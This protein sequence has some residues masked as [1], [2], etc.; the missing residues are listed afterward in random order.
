[1][2]TELPL[3]GADLRL[4]PG[5]LDR[6]AADALFERLLQAVPW[7][8]H[9]VRLFGRERA[10]PRLSCW[11]GDPGARY[12]YSGIERSP[13]EW[14]PELLPLRARLAAELGVDFN[15]VLANLYRSG[16]DA[17]GWHSDDEKELGPRPTI[18]SVSLGAARRFLIRQ[19]HGDA[20]LGVEL[21]HGSLLVMAG[22][23]QA[24]TRHSLPRT[25]RVVGPRVNLTFRRVAAP[26]QR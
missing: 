2:P 6:D 21:E 22:E 25:R 12:R 5:W 7:E 26:D 14:L 20:R 15:S 1:M 23:T 8:N 16:D 11:M 3:P 24:N 9:P 4:H 19:R 10:A 18:A 13:I 17:M